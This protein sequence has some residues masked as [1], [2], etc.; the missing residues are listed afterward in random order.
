MNHYLYTVDALRLARERA[1]QA[2]RYH[3]A[4]LSAEGV[5]S[6]PSPLR[7]SVARALA[8]FSRGS[9]WIVRRLDSCVA[10]DLGRSLAPAE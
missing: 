5:L 3:L 7:R 1:E 2:N 6:S 4:Q 9:A 10:D 8:T